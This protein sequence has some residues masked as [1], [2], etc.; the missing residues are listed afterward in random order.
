MKGNNREI[1]RQK[2]EDSYIEQIGSEKQSYEPHGPLK[3]PIFE[4]LLY[5]ATMLN[6]PLRGDLMICQ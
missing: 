4:L 2:I 6:I 5:K 1:Q 3:V